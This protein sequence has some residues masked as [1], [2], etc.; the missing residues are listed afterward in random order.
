MFKVQCLNTDNFGHV[1]H[2]N[3]RRKIATAP[4][5]RFAMTGRIIY[6]LDSRLRGNDSGD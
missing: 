5:R 3:D 6:F 1:F 2:R 4:E